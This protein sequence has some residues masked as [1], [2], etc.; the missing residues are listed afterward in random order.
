MLL[1]P[2][3]EIYLSVASVWEMVIKH[4]TGKLSLPLPPAQ[5]VP[6]RLAALGHKVLPIEHRHVLQLAELP[7]HHKD[8]FDRILVAQA[9]VEGMPIITADPLVM[10]YSIDAIRA[11][12]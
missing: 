12:M 2:K 1:E 10:A 9:Q 3:N 6:E 5:Y 8:P 4:G 11:A 7:A